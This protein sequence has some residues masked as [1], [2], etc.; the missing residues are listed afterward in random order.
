MYSSYDLYSFIVALMAEPCFYG[1]V[2]SDVNMKTFW[3]GL[4]HPLEFSDV[5]VAVEK[6]QSTMPTSKNLLSVLAGFTLRCDALTYAMSFLH[7]S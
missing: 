6:L 1:S 4:W 3:A 5:T 7:K 2:M